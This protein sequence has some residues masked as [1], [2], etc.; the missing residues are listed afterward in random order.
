MC[1]I[2]VE[3]TQNAREPLLILSQPQAVPFGV[4]GIFGGARPRSRPLVSKSPA[5]RPPLGSRTATEL[6]SALATG[7]HAMMIDA[8]AADGYYG[9]RRTRIHGGGR[10]ARR[11]WVGVVSSGNRRCGA[12][13]GREAVQEC[14]RATITRTRTRRSI[15]SSRDRPSTAHRRLINGQ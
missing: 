3:H 15:G 5:R 12:T 8:I 7:L 1:T 14:L 13:I 4:W 6:L 2:S 10:C 9:L 11:H